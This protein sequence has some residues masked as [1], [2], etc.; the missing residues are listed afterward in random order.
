[1]GSAMRVSQAAGEDPFAKVKGLITDMI[2]KLEE[3]AGAD[4]QHKAY[5]DKELAESNAKKDDKTAEIEKLSTKIDQDTSRSSQLKEEVAGLQAALAELAKA[6][7]EMDAIRK[8]E[9]D[10]FTVNKAE[11]EKGLEGVKLALK[12]LN[13]YYNAEGK[14][15]DAASGAGGGIIGLLEVVESDLTKGIAEM[16]GEEDSSQ[17][18]YE[19][20]TQANKIDKTEKDQAVKYKTKEYKDLDKNVAELTADRTSVQSELDAVNQYL[21]S[22]EDQCIAKAEPY[23]ERTARRAAEIAGLKQALQILDGES[24]LIQESSRNGHLRSVQRHV[25]RA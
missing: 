8:Q 15:H 17:S 7:A 13:E 4:A 21:A 25:S 24:A 18:T 6:Q 9:N 2:A 14:A 11:M 5:C 10:L 1:M 19:Q 16:V 23:A 3:E 12:V 20:D 22:L